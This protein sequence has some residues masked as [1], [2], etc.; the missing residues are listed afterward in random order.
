[1]KQSWISTVDGNPGE[2]RDALRLLSDKFSYTLSSSRFVR[3]NLKDKLIGRGV[4]R[5]KIDEILDNLSTKTVLVENNRFPAGLSA[6]ALHLLNNRF[7]VT[8]KNDIPEPPRKYEWHYPKSFAPR[9]YQLHSQK[10]IHDKLGLYRCMVVKMPTGAGKTFNACMTIAD[11][12][13]DTVY[14]VPSKLLMEQAYDDFCLFI[15]SD[16]VG[17]IG[18]GYSETGAPITVA[19]INSLYSAYRDKSRNSEKA[20]LRRKLVEQTEFVIVDEVLSQ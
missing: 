20:L 1:M 9:S 16:N 14:V 17:R 8:F 5:D 11:Y 6:S 12:G 19:I 13:L 18:G 4:D 3:N 10:L 7:D 15:G 2:V